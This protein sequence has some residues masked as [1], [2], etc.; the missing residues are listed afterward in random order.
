MRVA[1]SQCQAPV[2]RVGSGPRLGSEL[3]AGGGEIGEPGT[4]ASDRFAD[5]VNSVGE[6]LYRSAALAA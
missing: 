2:D 4:V 6:E 1:A 5:R 3:V